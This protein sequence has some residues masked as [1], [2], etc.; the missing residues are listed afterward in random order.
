VVTRLPLL[1][2]LARSFT[3]YCVRVERRRLTTKYLVNELAARQPRGLF[4]LANDPWIG[5]GAAMYQFGG[6]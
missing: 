6:R 2:A 5:V 3:R 1:R 4:N